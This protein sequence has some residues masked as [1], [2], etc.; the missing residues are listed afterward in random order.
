M[1]YSKA[2]CK[3]FYKNETFFIKV[4]SQEIKKEQK[5]KPKTGLELCRK[6]L[7]DP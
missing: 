3:Q 1:L 5:L 7:N 2:R 6:A 4:M